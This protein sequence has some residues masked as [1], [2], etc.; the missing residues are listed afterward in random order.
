MEVTTTDGTIFTPVDHVDLARLIY[1]RFGH[2]PEAA[3]EAWRR[4]LQNSATVEDFMGLVEYGTHT[5]N[6]EGHCQ[7]EQ[8][9]NHY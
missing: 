9:P 1:K 3:T 7:I 6:C 2:N 8:G 4:M 5:P